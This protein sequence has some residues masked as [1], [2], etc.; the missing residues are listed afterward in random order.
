MVSGVLAAETAPALPRS[1]LGLAAT[2]LLAAGLTVGG[3]RVMRG[4]GGTGEGDYEGGPTG[5]GKGAVASARE[6]LR[7]LFG[8]DAAGDPKNRPPGASTA[9]F[10]PVTPGILP[11]GSFPG[12]ILWPEVRP[13]ARIVAPLPRG[14]ASGIALQRPIGIPFDG[15]YLLY[16]WP[17]RRPPPTSILQRGSPA[18]LAFSTVDHWPLNMDAIQKFDEPLDLSCCSGIRVEI[19]NADRYPGTV[20]LVLYADDRPLG[21]APVRSTP[22]LQRDPVTAVPES[23]DFRISGAA[24]C[25]ELKVTFHRERQRAD[26]SARIAI[27]RFVLLP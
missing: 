15:Q 8:D 24:Q 20:S 19:W 21:T 6:V 18:S 9:L 27:E 26:K 5:G 16:R 12:V 10:P 17:Q 3:I 2:V 14:Q 25:K 1:L 4:H 13:V 11:D 7:D 22:D 23:I